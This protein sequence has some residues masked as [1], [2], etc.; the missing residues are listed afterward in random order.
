M[1]DAER[2]VYDTKPAVDE[3]LSSKLATELLIRL[4]SDLA[5]FLRQQ[6]EVAERI[7]DEPS[8]R[9]WKDIRSAAQKLN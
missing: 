6:I 5:R 8:V 4:G 9:T 2:S 1:S 7:P 3:H